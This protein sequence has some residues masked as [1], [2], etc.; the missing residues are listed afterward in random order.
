MS[1]TPPT[2]E[3]C[4]SAVI[5][6]KRRQADVMGSLS[7]CGAVHCE[8]PWEVLKASLVSPLPPARE[9]GAAGGVFFMFSRESPRADQGWVSAR[10]NWLLRGSKDFF[11]FKCCM[12]LHGTHE[13]ADCLAQTGA[14]GCQ[15][16]RHL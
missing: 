12:C 1:A 2:S 7:L 15:W 5:P 6:V 3:I 9:G 10:T 4:L 8:L 11:F 13:D 14:D 16:T